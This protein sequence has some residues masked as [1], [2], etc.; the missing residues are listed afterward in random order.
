MQFGNLWRIGTSRIYTKEEMD[1]AIV[2]PSDFEDKGR[3]FGAYYFYIQQIHT[4]DPDTTK[5][6]VEAGNVY[7]K[8]NNCADSFQYLR[9]DSK[10]YGDSM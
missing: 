3:G 4:S 2:K 10:R 6:H 9:S 8:V 1:Q 5:K 7:Y